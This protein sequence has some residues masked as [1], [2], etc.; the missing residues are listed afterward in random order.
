[1]YR[2]LNTKRVDESDSGVEYSSEDDVAR[3]SDSVSSDSD[4]PPTWRR[5]RPKPRARPRVSSNLAAIL[6]KATGATHVQVRNDGRKRDSMTSEPLTA[7]GGG[8]ASGG[9]GASGPLTHPESSSEA[10]AGMQALHAVHSTL[11]ARIAA[12]EEQGKKQA[13]KLE[14]EARIT[15]R[16]ESMEQTVQRLHK[17]V[18]QL[19]E[20]M[21]HKTEVD[22]RHDMLLDGLDARLNEQAEDIADLVK[23]LEDG[24]SA[25]A[26]LQGTLLATMK[27]RDEE[28]AGLESEQDERIAAMDER[29][30]DQDARI[31]ALETRMTAVS[32]LVDTSLK[33]AWTQQLEIALGAARPVPLT[34][35]EETELYDSPEGAVSRAAAAGETLDMHAR[36]SL[37]GTTWVA[38]STSSGLHYFKEHAAHGHVA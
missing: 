10:D 16:I 14:H 24:I 11:L 32:T 29:D 26:E 27:H 33:P 9:M 12:L 5:K 28:A 8:L 25:R 18:K 36:F 3:Q 1:M 13:A 38:A 2:R 15:S 30:S 20:D 19:V 23:G 31:E 35:D 37:D 7:A 6:G 21:R 22:A 34:L 4:E 17:V